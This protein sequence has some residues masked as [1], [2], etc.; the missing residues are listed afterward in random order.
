VLL[1][2][3]SISISQ[4]KTEAKRRE[5]DALRQIVADAQA[6]V[7]AAHAKAGVALDKQARVEH[8][9]AEAAA[10]AEAVAAKENKYGD[11]RIA[12]LGRPYPLP[13]HIVQ[14]LHTSYLSQSL[15][16]LT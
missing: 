2:L 14:T 10:K 13:V 3:K 8:L 1:A 11:A 16:E 12:E 15:T 6:E 9:S 7:D 4:L 5:G